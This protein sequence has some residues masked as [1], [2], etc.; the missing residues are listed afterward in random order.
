[1]AA[2]STVSV[3]ID[4]EAA[5]YVAELGAQEPFER[6]LEWIRQNV[7]GLCSVEANFEQDYECGTDHRVSFDATVEHRCPSHEPI[8]RAWLDWVIDTF[9]RQVSEHFTLLTMH[10][11]DHAG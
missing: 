7:P 9:P 11:R 6:M 4:P 10:V 1:M 3:K 2:P 5:K 8:R